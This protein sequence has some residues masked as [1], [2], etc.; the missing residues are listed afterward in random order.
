MT[1]VPSVSSW[2]DGKV[3]KQNRGN[4]SLRGQ[5]MNVLQRVERRQ[6]LPSKRLAVVLR[7]VDELRKSAFLCIYYA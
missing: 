2:V 4:A 7:K 3:I 6:M 1:E 5:L